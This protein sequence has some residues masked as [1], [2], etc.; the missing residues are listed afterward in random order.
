[1]RDW[2]LGTPEGDWVSM[3]VISDG[4]YGAPEGIVTS[5]PATCS[6]G[7]FSIVQGLEIN[8]FSQTRMQASWD[9]LVAERDTVKEL[10]LI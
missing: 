2:A 4:S 1:M 8:E 9:E 3:S 5:V 6:G 7:D 10:G